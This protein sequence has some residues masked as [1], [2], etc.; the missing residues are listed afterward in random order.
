MLK[1]RGVFLTTMIIAFGAL[2]ALLFYS[3]VTSFHYAGII[4]K[5]GQ[6]SLLS[7]YIGTFFYFFLGAIGLIGVIQWRRWGISLIAVGTLIDFTAN[8]IRYHDPIIWQGLAAIVIPSA[9][10]VWSVIR[11]L[12]NFT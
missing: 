11:K 7:L 1:E 2:L 6:L 3:L 4:L 12:E 5:P 8:I 10:L 9:L